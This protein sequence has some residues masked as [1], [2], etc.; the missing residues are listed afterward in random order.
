[1]NSD[2]CPKDGRDMFMFFSFL[3]LQ[4]HTKYGDR[5]LTA[6]KSYFEKWLENDVTGI[7]NKIEKMGADFDKWIYFITG[8]DKIKRFKCTPEV[9]FN[10]LCG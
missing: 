3:Y 4:L 5:D 1:M 2:P 9:I 8:N 10:D 6:V 7:L